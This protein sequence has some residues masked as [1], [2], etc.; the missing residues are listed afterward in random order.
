VGQQG[1]FLEG[2][3]NVTIEPIESA[4]VAPEPPSQLLFGTGLL[5]FVVF[6]WLRRRLTPETV[7]YFN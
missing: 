3:S 2:T 7:R 5:G 1:I 6:F 4:D